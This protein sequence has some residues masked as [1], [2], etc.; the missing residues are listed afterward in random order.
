MLAL[1]PTFPDPKEVKDSGPVPL[2]HRA[3]CL[4]VQPQPELCQGKQSLSELLFFSSACTLHSL[5]I[6]MAI[7]LNFPQIFQSSSVNNMAR[8]KVNPSDGVFPLPVPAESASGCLCPSKCNSGGT[9]LAF[10]FLS[11]PPQW[12]RAFLLPFFLP[13]PQGLSIFGT[14]GWGW[15]SV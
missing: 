13:L 4:C 1:Q 9:G 14:S 11:L 5:L 12:H 8:T 7:C 3:V 6:L 10:T 2:A 15:G